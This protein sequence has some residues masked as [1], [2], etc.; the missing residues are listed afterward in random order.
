MKPLSC[1]SNLPCLSCP[2]TENSCP[3]RRV[4]R[5]DPAHEMAM[6]AVYAT[7]NPDLYAHVKLLALAGAV[8]NNRKLMEG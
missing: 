2:N 3:A 5:N 8:E 1:R 4:Q 6:R 7:G